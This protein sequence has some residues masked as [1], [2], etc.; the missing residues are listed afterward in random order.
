M[1]AVQK[2][3]GMERWTHLEMVWED[4]IFPLE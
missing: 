4:E 2:L 1:T 3:F